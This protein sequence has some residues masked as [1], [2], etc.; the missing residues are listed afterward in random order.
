MKVITHANFNILDRV[1]RKV[2]MMGYTE[3]QTGALVAQEGYLLVTMVDDLMDIAIVPYVTDS[4]GSLVPVFPGYEDAGEHF[5]ADD[6]T[7][8]FIADNEE[9]LFEIPEVSNII[10]KFR[11][12]VANV[13]SVRSI[14]GDS[15]DESV[16]FRGKTFFENCDRD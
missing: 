13:L 16:F 3:H 12:Y 10:D 9:F 1:G 4:D 7:Y 11:S 6:G 15:R 14:E 2:W 8:L 5:D